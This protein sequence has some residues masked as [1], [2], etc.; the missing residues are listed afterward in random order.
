MPAV[1]A[2]TLIA[3]LAHREGAT[4]PACGTP[5]C[6]HAL[7]LSIA[8]GFRRD[9]RCLGCLATALGR[10]AEAFRQHAIAHIHHRDCY[11]GAWRWTTEREGP[12]VLAVADGPRTTDPSAGLDPAPLAADAEWDA[13][14]MGCG[15]LVLELRT[16]LSALAPGA[17]LRIVARDPGAPEDL[18]AWCNMTGHRLVFARHPDYLIERRR[19]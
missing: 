18:P 12:C 7:L 1:T 9:P 14:D 17:A 5:L 3:E 13:G 16:R 4:C 15:D 8:A 6:G 10:R 11:L 19:D 2:A